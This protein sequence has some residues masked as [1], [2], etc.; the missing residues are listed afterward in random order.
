MPFGT[1]PE[2]GQTC[3]RV[4]VQAVQNAR[5]ERLQIAVQVLAMEGLVLH[6]HVGER[7]PLFRREWLPVMVL[8][9]R[10]QEPVG[11]NSNS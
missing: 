5:R 11:A 10:I 9:F 8:T 7:G 3:G 1:A 4:V 2:D 6:G